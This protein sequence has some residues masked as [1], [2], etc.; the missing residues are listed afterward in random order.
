MKCC[1]C[2]SQELPNA[3]AEGEFYCLDHFF[4]IWEVTLVEK[5]PGTEIMER[6]ITRRNTILAYA[7]V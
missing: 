1:I 3:I 5:Y 7:V 6:V 4:Q 2:G